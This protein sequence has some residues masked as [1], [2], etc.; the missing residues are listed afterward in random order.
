MWFFVY[1]V[2]S[3]SLL[4]F[5]PETPHITFSSHFCGSVITL[6]ICG[7]GLRK[8]CISETGYPRGFLL[9]LLQRHLNHRRMMSG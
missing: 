4:I 2:A 8:N 5:P 1:F 3:D 6:G 7:T 9:E